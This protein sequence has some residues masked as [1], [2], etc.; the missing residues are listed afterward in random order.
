MGSSDGHSTAVG[1]RSSCS[2]FHL[3][4][5][6]FDLSEV[7]FGNQQHTLDREVTR[8][9]SCLAVIMPTV[10]TSR[11]QEAC[12]L[13]ACGR[14]QQSRVVVA[15]EPRSGLTPLRSSRS[16]R[17][18]CQVP[19]LPTGRRSSTSRGLTRICFETGRE[20]LTQSSETVQEPDTVNGCL[21]LA[22]SR[23]TAERLN[24]KLMTL[25]DTSTPSPTR[26]RTSLPA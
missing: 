18:S 15:G 21:V 20:T 8:S 13:S 4:I 2:R 9:E 10:P 5:S 14:P 19:Q 16:S 22:P 23:N 17:A 3:T 26:E 1:H 24:R 11:W 7:V 6:E 12:S 25:Q